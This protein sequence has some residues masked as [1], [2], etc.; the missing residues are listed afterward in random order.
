[1][2]DKD[3]LVVKH[4]MKKKNRLER[5]V[6]SECNL[7]LGSV[8]MTKKIILLSHPISLELFFSSSSSYSSSSNIQFPIHN[9]NN[10]KEWS[11]AYVL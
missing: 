5:L 4:E 3:S 2:S 8:G 11:Q 10:A 9:S 7:L 6:M 1:M